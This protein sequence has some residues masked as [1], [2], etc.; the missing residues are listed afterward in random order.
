MSGNKW[1]RNQIDVDN[2]FACNIAL[3]ILDDDVDHEPL[4]I[5]QCKQ[6]NDWPKWKEAIE[7]ELISLSKREVFRPI[8]RTPEGV[9][10]VG[11]KW[12]FVRKRNE[13]GEIARYKARL[14]AQ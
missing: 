9:K 2:T 10:P 14:V 8:V 5:G 13:K 6:R 7:A 11:Y 3:D 12:V 4:S 1:N